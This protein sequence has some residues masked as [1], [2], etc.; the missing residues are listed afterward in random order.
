MTDDETEPI[1]QRGQE[2]DAHSGP[3]RA[4]GGI[5]DGTTAQADTTG[6]AGGLGH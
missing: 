5:Q 2:G 4:D 1:L 3:P 6:G